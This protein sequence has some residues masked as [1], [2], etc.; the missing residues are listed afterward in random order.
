MDTTRWVA[1][2]DTGG[3]RHQVKRGSASRAPDTSVAA[4]AAAVHPEGMA[5]RSRRLRSASD[6]TAGLG[7]FETICTPDG[8]PVPSRPMGWHPWIGCLSK[9][10][11]M[12]RW[13]RFAQ[14]P[15]TSYDA[16]GIEQQPFTALTWCRYAVPQS[17][18]NFTG[19][20]LQPLRHTTTSL[21]RLGTMLMT[22]RPAAARALFILCDVGLHHETAAVRV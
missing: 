15:A 14:P 10:R 9:S 1:P 16:F 5:A 7:C 6:D 2:M 3:H 12:F 21:T 19:I 20:S 8:V 17:S 13:Y 11:G 4:S 22:V 18:A